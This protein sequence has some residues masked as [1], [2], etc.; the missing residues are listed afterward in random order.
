MRWQ[1][2]SGLR[3]TGRERMRMR[4]RTETRP[5]LSDPLT[6]SLSLWER[7]PS[8]QY[9]GEKVPLPQGEGQGEGMRRFTR[10]FVQSPL[11]ERGPCRA[12]VFA[13][14]IA[15]AGASSVARGN[16]SCPTLPPGSG[17]EWEYRQGPDFGLCYA[18]DARDQHQLFGLYLGFAPSFHA[19][20]RADASEGTVGGYKV[21]W[22]KAQSD[23][24]RHPLGREALFDV[25][26]PNKDLP[27]MKIHVWV[28]AASDAELARGLDVLRH[29]EFK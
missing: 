17:L 18:R 15:V 12:I 8:K 14:L 29:I 3:Y 23:D 25:P 13:V 9:A 16:D 22:Y 27:S 10:A 19:S 6:L 1:T 21:S 4:P 28:Y 7:E 20:E 2:L 24:P 11:R 26:G 5:E